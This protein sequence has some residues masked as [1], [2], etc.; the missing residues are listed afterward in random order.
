MNL[1]KSESQIDAMQQGGVIL[2]KMLQKLKTMIKPG[3]KTMDL[4]IEFIN[5]CEQYKVVPSCKNYRTHGLPPFPTGLC[6]SINNQAVHCYPEQGQIIKSGDSIAIDTVIAFKGMHVDS[7]FTMVAGT[8]DSEIARFI[9]VTKMASSAGIKQAIAGNH[10]GDISYAIQTV[11]QLAG[12]DVLRDFV[13]HG[14]GTDMHELP[15]IP[16]Y[17]KK[18]QGMKLEPGMT[19]AIE[20]LACQGEPDI[21]YPGPDAWQTKMA[22]GKNFAIF[23]HT[24]LVTKKD[25][26]I[27]TK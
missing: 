8:A 20:T 27:I 13:G 10:V 12:F 17:G 11:M 18:G 23:E 2:R 26:I 3:L 6:I 4:E 19:L 15:D 22:D 1:I 16:C 21:D 14:I 7:A 24:V 5:M 25:P 9:E